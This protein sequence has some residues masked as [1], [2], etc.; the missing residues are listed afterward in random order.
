MYAIRSYYD[1]TVDIGEF[2]YPEEVNIPTYKPTYKGNKRQI[3][4]AVEAIKE[5]KKPL[6]Y[7]GGGVVLSDAYELVRDLAVKTQIPAV[8][9]LMARGV[10]GAKNPLLP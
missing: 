5:A 3:E 10:M 1:I 8:E 7:I 6:L 9:T 4:K 2:V